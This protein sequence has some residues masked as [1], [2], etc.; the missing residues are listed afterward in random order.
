[1][2][3]SERAAQL[4]PSLTLS[5]DSK[6]KAMKAEGIDVCGFGAGEPDFDT[7]EHIK[8]AA[9]EALEAGFTKYTPSAG[10]PELRQ[11]IAEKLA[12]DNDLNYRATQVILATCQPGDEVVIP[13][14]YWVSYPEMVRLVGAEPVIVP[15]SERNSWKMRAEDFENAMTPRTKMLIMNSPGNPTGAVYTREELQAIV[16]VAAEEDIYI[17][18]DEIYEK[19]VYDDAKHVSIASLSQAAYDLAITI[20]GFSKSYAMTGWRLGYL[21]APD[22]V[23]K[24]V[25]SIQSHTASNPSSFSQFGAL[26]ALKGDQQPL[27]DMREEFDIRRNYMF[28]RVSK[29]SNVTAVKPQ[30]AFY[31]LVNISQLGLTSQN[32]ADR[33]LSKANVAVVPGAAFGDDRTIRLSYATSIDVIKKGLDR[34]QDFCR[35][36]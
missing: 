30:G 34:F 11:A 13:A 33:L 5:I 3:I 8:K 36:L 12:A 10:I 22:A 35:T 24:A 4:S 23:A 26:A 28:D 27:I 25:D 19:L 18:S 31:V 2:E 9:I 20:N 7:P 15:T 21:A 16:D 6:A 32:F 17:L 1:M 29:I 14:P